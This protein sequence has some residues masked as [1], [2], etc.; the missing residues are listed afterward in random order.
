MQ[1]TGRIP[2]HNCEPTLGQIALSLVLFSNNLELA[3]R[4]ITSQ[5]WAQ[6]HLHWY[7]AP[8]LQNFLYELRNCQPK[9][10]PITPSPIVFLS[11]TE[12]ALQV[13]II[14]QQN[15]LAESFFDMI[16]VA[17][18]V[19]LSLNRNDSSSTLCIAEG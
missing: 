13:I 2:K 7:D 17:N 4:V 8:A 14:H 1:S 18:T 12:L 3:L 5:S 6:S 15:L 16:R 10:G 9:L 19:C 11:S